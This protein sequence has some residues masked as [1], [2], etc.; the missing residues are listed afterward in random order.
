[1]ISELCTYDLATGAIHV[2]LRHEG[3]IEA[4]NWHP[5]G[6]L[7]VNGEGR[8][9]RVALD[10]PALVAIDVGRIGGL[11]NDHGLS[12]DGLTLAISAKSETGASCVYLLPA[13]GGEP[14]RVTPEVPSWWHSWSPDGS[15]LAYASMR[16]SGPVAIRTCA[17]DGSDE[18]LVTDAFDHADGPDYSPDGRWVW[19]NGE[20]DG[21]VDLWRAHPDGSGLERMTTR[22]TVDWFPHPSPDG[23]HVLYLAYAS[24]TLGHPADREV[25]LMLMPASGGE[26]T[27]AVR[28]RGGQGSINVPC[29]APD[30]RGFAFMRYPA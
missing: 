6:Y 11:N 18:V 9:W 10:E 30:S 15:R 19:F 5:D 21:M 24:G 14:S 23:R 13:A 4:P 27:E 16:D 20:R 3:R 26:A 1:M 28:L 29:W 8:L 17:L 12:P 22:S 7:V 2:V 25:A